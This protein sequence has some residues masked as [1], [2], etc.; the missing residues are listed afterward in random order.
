M[1]RDVS[2]VSGA[3]VETVNETVV[4]VGRLMRKL[5]GGDGI[6]MLPQDHNGIECEGV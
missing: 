5:H 2:V 6:V 3:R 1:R 4:G